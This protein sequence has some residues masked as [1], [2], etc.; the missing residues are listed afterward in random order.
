MDKKNV[1]AQEIF[2]AMVDEA[3][4]DLRKSGLDKREM[5]TVI[6]EHMGRQY[7]EKFCK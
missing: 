4:E 7:A 6:E 2:D 3:I 5:F 1:M